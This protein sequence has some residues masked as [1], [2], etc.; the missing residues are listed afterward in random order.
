MRKHLVALAVL[1][2]GHGLSAQDPQKP[3]GI[4]Q[5]PR[6]IIRRSVDL[7]TTD[8]IVRDNQGQFVANLAKN[9]FDVLEDGVPQ[10]LITFV[11]THG[12]RVLNDISA[13][14]PPVQ[15]G[16]LLPPPRPT[17]ARRSARN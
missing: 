13:P 8:V 9:D 2:A 7:V 3:E 15:E 12:G 6:E 11:L 4:L 14:P 17:N 1:A 16:I 10:N 5:P